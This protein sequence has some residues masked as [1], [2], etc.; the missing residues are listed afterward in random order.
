MKIIT[1]QHTDVINTLKTKDYKCELISE[2]H[3]STPRSYE[4]LSQR[5]LEKC[6]IKSNPIFGWLQT[7]EGK[8]IL[9]KDSIKRALEMVHF[10]DY[11]MLYLDVPEEYI[12]LQDF[13]S[14]VDLRCE[15]ERIDPYYFRFENFPVN[16]VF[17][18]SKALEIQ[19]TF[20][21]IKKE[22]IVEQK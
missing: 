6:N 9:D 20:P 3:K 12:D 15:E 5:L 16:V 19:V 22:W 14:F 8:N 1:F 10:N 21:I 11:S 18:T 2:Y 17:D 4:I 13:Y 7:I